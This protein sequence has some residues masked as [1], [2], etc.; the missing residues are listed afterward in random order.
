MNRLIGII[1]VAASTVALSAAPASAATTETLSSTSGAPGAS[2]TISATGFAA[3]TSIDVFFD[4]TDVAIAVSNASGAVSFAIPVPSTAQPGKHWIT[5]DQLSNH[6]AAQAPFTVVMSWPQGG[7]GPSWRGYNPL[8]NTINTSN[9]AQLTQAW[10]QVVT[11]FGNPKPFVDYNNALYVFDENEVLHAYTTAGKLLWTAAPGTTFRF[12]QVAPVAYGGY[13]YVGDSTGLVTAYPYMCRTDGGVCT[14]QKWKVKL[15]GAVNGL[16]QR[17]GF[18]YAAGADGVVHVLNASTG[19]AGTSIV[20]F[21]TGA[22]TQPVSF[23]EDGT[24]YMVQ[25][26]AVSAIGPTG[27]GGGASFASGVALSTVAVGNGAGYATSTDGNLNQVPGGWSATIGG[28]CDIAPA[29]ANSLVYAASCNSIGAYDANTGAIDW[30][31]AVATQPQGLAIANGIL[32]ACV[33]YRI[34]AYDASYG[35]LLASLGPCVGPPEVVEGTLYTTNAKLIASTLGGAVTSS[36][37]RVHAERPNP[38]RLRASARLTRRCARL[39]RARGHA[40]RVCR[41]PRSRA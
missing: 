15:P 10:D 2:V 26:A 25:P 20:P 22:I 27:G 1:A 29:Y 24:A 12:S 7:W 18:V 41:A 3:D 32:Y 34:Y 17:N 39:A 38:R 6:L 21:Y 19:A 5:L 11:S 30:S 31:V 8:E 16:T 14:T 23:G 28:T 35:G 37:G 33:G 36:V 4:T 9:V 13:V 40:L